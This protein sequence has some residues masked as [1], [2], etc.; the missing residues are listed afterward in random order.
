M[1]TTELIKDALD[2]ADKRLNLLD[3]PIT[4]TQRHYITFALSQNLVKNLVIPDVVKSFYC[5]E[6]IDGLNK[7]TE[8]CRVCRGVE[9]SIPKQ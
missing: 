6:E 2:W 8:Q 7:C 5:D 9:Q 3:E 1:D 4:E